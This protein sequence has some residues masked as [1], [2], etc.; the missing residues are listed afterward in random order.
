MRDGPTWSGGGLGYPMEE[1]FGSSHSTGFNAVFADGSVRTIRYGVDRL[2]F[3]YV[4]HRE[5]GKLFDWG[6]I[7][8]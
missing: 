7:E 1:R 3:N 5:D 6:D 8:P 4:C 2:L